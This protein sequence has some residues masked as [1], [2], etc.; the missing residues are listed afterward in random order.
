MLSSDMSEPYH[1]KQPQAVDSKE[2]HRR[3]EFRKAGFTWREFA[4]RYGYKNADSARTTMSVLKVRDLL[5][6]P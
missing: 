1:V 2:F 4:E 5:T 3:L 6:K